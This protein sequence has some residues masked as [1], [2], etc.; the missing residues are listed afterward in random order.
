MRKKSKKPLHFEI[1]KNTLPISNRIKFCAYRFRIVSE[2]YRL[3]TIVR[4]QK[5]AKSLK[6]WQL[7]RQNS[8]LMISL[9]LAFITIVALIARPDITYAISDEIKQSIN[10]IVKTLPKESTH[11]PSE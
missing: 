6:S 5:R 11:Y 9:C 3:K 1:T 10:M 8:I 4:L 2:K 7:Q